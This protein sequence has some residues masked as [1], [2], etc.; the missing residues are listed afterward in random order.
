MNLTEKQERRIRNT[1]GV[2]KNIKS[3]EFF[4]KKMMS[5]VNLKDVGF[6]K[7]EYESINDGKVYTST[8]KMRLEYFEKRQRAS[9]EV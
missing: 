6:A 3:V 9:K 2:I 5:G 1:I 7:V 8:I 4:K